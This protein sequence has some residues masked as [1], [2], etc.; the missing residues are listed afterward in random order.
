MRNCVVCP[1]ICICNEDTIK[2]PILTADGYKVCCTDCAKNHEP[3][4]GL[5][6]REEKLPSAGNFDC[7]CPCHRQ[8]A[9]RLKKENL[10]KSSTDMINHPPHYQSD[11]GMEVINVI[12]AF[13]LNYCIGNSL[14]YLLRSGRKTKDPVEDYKKAVWYINREISKLENKQE[15]N[16][17]AELKER[18]EGCSE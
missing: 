4:K 17:E 11:N 14:K 5:G 16:I 3:G 12:E 6:W 10:M 9:L 18:A 2:R 13:G 8:R 1:T 15:V 7:F